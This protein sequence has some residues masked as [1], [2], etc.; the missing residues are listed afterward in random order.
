[1]AKHW[2]KKKKK[3]E[4]ISFYCK[5]FYHLFIYVSILPL[6][7][8]LSRGKNLDMINPFNPATSVCLSQVRTRISNVICCGLILCS[9]EIKGDCS[10]CWYWW[11]CWQAQLFK[12][13]SHNTAVFLQAYI[14]SH[15]NACM[16]MKKLYPENYST[17]MSKKLGGK[18]QH[19]SIIYWVFLYVTF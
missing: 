12:H 3:K 13:F 8:Q 6:E 18:C 5:H 7:I 17:R 1:M 19:W 16:L 9:I 11:N 10:F 2:K 14:L 4:R 15:F